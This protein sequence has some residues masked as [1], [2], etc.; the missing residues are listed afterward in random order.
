MSATLYERTR[1]VG[2]ILDD[3]LNALEI[4]MKFLK[5]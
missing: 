3:I 2:D 1:T 5:Y 4:A